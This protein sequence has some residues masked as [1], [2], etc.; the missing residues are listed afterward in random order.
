MLAC[1]TKTEQVTSVPDTIKRDLAIDALDVLHARKNI[2]R[3]SPPSDYLVFG[4]HCGM[5]IEKCSQMLLVDTLRN[6]VYIDLSGEYYNTRDLSV[7]AEKNIVGYETDIAEL[8]DKLPSQLLTIKEK[9]MKFGCPDCADQCLFYIE[10][11][12]GMKKFQLYIDT[13]RSQLPE[14]LKKYTD[15]ID[16]VIKKISS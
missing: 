12:S 2:K 13:D 7:F 11:G 9:E 1:N 10:I 6:E 14:F 3:F 8:V 4:K 16:G 5:C 15:I